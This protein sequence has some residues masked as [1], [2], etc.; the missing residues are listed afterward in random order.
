[1]PG[2]GSALPA[3]F[4]YIHDRL[5][6]SEAVDV[7]VSWG[8]AT[9]DDA[10]A[11]WVGVGVGEDGEGTESE[12]DFPFIGGGVLEEEFEISLIVEV[13]AVG[14]P[15]LKAA[16]DRSVAIAA[17][18]EEEI[19]DDIEFG[20]LIFNGKVGKWKTHFF[21]TDTANGHRVFLTLTG[22]ARI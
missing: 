16:F 15:S 1:M 3:I 6:K 9:G 7:P 2:S 20:G 12:R 8:P 14:D 21:R 5:S 11:A 10:P 19:R 13:L 17:I 18:V 4:E 22:K